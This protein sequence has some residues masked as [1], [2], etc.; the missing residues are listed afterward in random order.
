[1][2]NNYSQGCTYVSPNQLSCREK[3]L[4]AW[5]VLTEKAD[6]PFGLDDWSGLDI[7]AADDGGL[8]ISSGPESFN[9]ELFDHFIGL[10][11]KNSWINVDSISFSGCYF[12]DKLRADE[13]GGFHIRITRTG[14][15]IGFD[16]SLL[17]CLTDDQL[18]QIEQY[19]RQPN[20]V[21]A[22]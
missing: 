3:I 20:D 12:C 15:L 8:Y 7:Q 1:M 14:K 22:K 5:R 2:A 10:M 4:K 6:K 21:T 9:E 16:T 17:E 18:L 19:V 11:L 13:F